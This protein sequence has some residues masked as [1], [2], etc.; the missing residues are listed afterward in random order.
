MKHRLSTDRN[1]YQTM[2]V[3]ESP[4]VVVVVVVVVGVPDNLYV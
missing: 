3:R 1:T 4:G 2:C